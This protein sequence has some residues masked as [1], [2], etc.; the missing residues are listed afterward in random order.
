MT[1]FSANSMLFCCPWSPTKASGPIGKEVARRGV[2]SR[3][4]LGSSYSLGIEGKG[5]INELLQTFEMTRN[6]NWDGYG[7]ERVGV[8]ALSNAYRFLEALPFGSY[9]TGVGAEPDGSLT[10]EWHSAP[11]CTLSISIDEDGNL[12]YAA[13]LPGS[14]KAYGSEPFLDSVPSTILALA[15]EIIST[16]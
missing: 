11:R 16:K 5:I 14:R 8:V 13:L 2:E 1:A 10:L 3:E 6:S 7:A 4:I 12:H 9:P 15:H